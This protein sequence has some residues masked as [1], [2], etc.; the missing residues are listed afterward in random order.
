MMYGARNLIVS[1]SECSV[2]CMKVYQKKK[3]QICSGITC[4]GKLNGDGDYKDFGS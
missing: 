4:G 1:F 3:N 2:T